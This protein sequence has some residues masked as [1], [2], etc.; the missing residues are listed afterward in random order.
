MVYI[1]RFRITN[2][3]HKNKRDLFWV[4]LLIMRQEIDYMI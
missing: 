1:E 2:V 4:L 3:L